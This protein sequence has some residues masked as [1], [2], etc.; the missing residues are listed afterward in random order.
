MRTFTILFL[1][2]FQIAAVQAQDFSSVDAH[3]QAAPSNVT[4]SVDKLAAYLN[5]NT[6]NNLE[7]VRA[8]YVWI[9]HNIA[10][11][12]KTFF[13]GKSTPETSAEHT[14][15]TRKG[16][17]QGYSE[18][19][20][21]LCDYSQIPCFIVSGYSKG[22]GYRPG[23]KFSESDHAWN[24]VQIDG[25]WQ[26]IDATWGAGFVDDKQRFKQKFTEEY[27]L[28]PPQLYILKHL[29]SDP[30]WQLL[31]CPIT[32]DD[33]QKDDAHINQ[34]LQKSGTCFHFNDTIAA[35]QK[36]NHID[37]MVNSAERSFRFFPS[38]VDIPG[39]AYLNLAFEMG[40]DLQTYYEKD[41]YTKALELNRK[42]LSINEKAYELLR[43][44]KS[45]QGRNAANICKQ[46]I[47]SLKT[48]IKSL[49]KFMK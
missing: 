37:Q 7:K 17:C 34:V 3:A 20:K 30:M 49:E 4:R 42:M 14:L 10:Y 8:Y 29:P 23:K 5:Q 47:S 21:A 12:T 48:N 6:S 46:N 15:K 35:Y 18:L 40:S 16:I 2:I 45:D 19:F 11:D 28:A 32:I 33:Y 31:P 39:F 13:R 43:K 41:D 26:L 36:L 1:L 24:A 22:Y 27:F 25:Q 38:N 44:S 9:S